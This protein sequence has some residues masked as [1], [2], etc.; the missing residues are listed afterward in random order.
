MFERLLPS[1][2]CRRFMT[3]LGK[4]LEEAMQSDV[5]VLSEYTYEHKASRTK[6]WTS[7]G[8]GFFK[9]YRTA[10]IDDDSVLEPMLNRWDRCVLWREF[11]VSLRQYYQ[12]QKNEKLN[13]VLNTLR[14]GRIKEH[15]G[16][17]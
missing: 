4:E 1:A 13:T 5:W 17:P 10:G 12:D 8:Y 9:L 3:E 11:H 15:G 16:T 2:L 14:L 6:L 7:S